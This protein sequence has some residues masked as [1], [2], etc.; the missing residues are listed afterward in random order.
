MNAAHLEGLIAAAVALALALALVPLLRRVALAL[1]VVDRPSAPGG[2]KSQRQPV[3]LLGGVAVAAAAVFAIFATSAWHGGEI[4]S[5]FDGCGNV[6]LA[7]ALVFGVGLV[8]DWFKDRVGPLLKFLGQFASI[9][10]LFDERFAALIAGEADR[11]EVLYLLATTLWFLT[12]VNAVNFIDNMNGLCAGLSMISFLVGLFGLESD[13]DIRYARIAGGLGGALLGFL[14]YN[15]PSARIYLG[16]AGSHL[17]GFFLA[18]VTLDFTSGFLSSGSSFYGLDAYVPAM[19]L[20]GVPLFDILFSVVRRRREGRPLFHGDARHLSHRLV[21]AG[22]DAASAV[23]LLW[24]V[25]L[26]LTAW[27]VIALS[28]RPLGRYAMLLVILVALTLLSSILVRLE[29][30]R[31]VPRTGT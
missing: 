7:G 13:S 3:P 30:R 5:A 15:F 27:G 9:V 4:A 23:M 26:I 22:L 8:D 24:G 12:V 10:I 11:G 31:S 16:D 20:L 19:L 6:W 1:D 28:Q 25:H 17:A 21:G 18:V 2:R 14:P 29:A